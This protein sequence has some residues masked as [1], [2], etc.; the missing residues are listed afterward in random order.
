M[1][2]L[3]D[4]VKEASP[5]DLTDYE[6][7]FISQKHNYYSQLGTIEEPEAI[8]LSALI[9]KTTDSQKQQMLCYSMKSFIRMLYV[10]KRDYIDSNYIITKYGANTDSELMNRRV[11]AIR[12]CYRL[13]VL[14]SMAEEYFSYCFSWIF[15]NLAIFD[16]KHFYK[17]SDNHEE[18]ATYDSHNGD[19]IVCSLLN[20]PHLETSPSSLP[21]TDHLNIDLKL[22]Q[23]VS[24]TSLKN[25]GNSPLRWYVFF[26]D[27][28]DHVYFVRAITLRKY[29][30]EMNIQP[31]DGKYDVSSFISSLD[32]FKLFLSKSK[33]L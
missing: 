31:I 29:I 15:R 9:G 17:G 11:E 10:F 3:I 2:Q 6:L 4:Y 32:E 26:S 13:Q 28:G 33:A 30:N 19:L 7:P 20:G 18:F 5:V 16:S 21:A 27:S 12:K 23:S 24:V 1:D 25:F 14:G 8:A 22:C